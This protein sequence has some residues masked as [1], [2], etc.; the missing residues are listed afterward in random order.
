MIAG[1][2]S[3]LGL[4]DFSYVEGGVCQAN[5][6]VS[7]YEGPANTQA[8][9]IC[10]AGT[11]TCDIYGSTL[12]ACSGQ[13]LPQAEDDCNTPE[14][15]N[16]DGIVEACPEVVAEEKSFTSFGSTGN[17]VI[18]DSA[19]DSEGN[20]YIVGD[21]TGTI[22]LGGDDLTSVVAE[23]ATGG[24]GGAGGSEET[25]GSG[26]VGSGESDIFVAKFDSTGT[27][28]WS[29][30][31]GDA[32]YQH[33]SAIAIDHDDH[34][35]LTGD[36]LGSIPFDGSAFDSTDDSTQNAFVAKLDSDGKYVWDQT[37]DST[38]D[39]TLY[40][41]DVA[42]NSE[43]SVYIIGFYG[44][45]I[46]DLNIPTPNN[47]S[48]KDDDVY[49]I[50]LDQQGTLTWADDY[51]FLEINFIDFGVGVSIDDNDSIILTGNFATTS[52]FLAK[53][54]S[55]HSWS[56]GW[57][58][59]LDGKE[60]VGR[61]LQVL[62]DSGN[63]IYLLGSYE[64]QFQCYLYSTLK[65]LDVTSSGSSDFFIAKIS[66]S[67]DKAVWSKTFGAS[68]VAQ[69][70]L[71]DVFHDN[72]SMKLALDETGDLV[73]TGSYSG[74]VSFDGGTSYLTA[75]NTD[76]SIFVAKLDPANGTTKWSKSFGDVEKVQESFSLATDS[77]DNV[78]VFG[79]FE[80]SILFNGQTIQSKGLNDTLWLKLGP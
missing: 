75:G 17:E 40:S 63:N 50:E 16:C 35:I 34:L 25:G 62:T 21:F 11:Q 48:D 9:G 58:C 6:E 70:P 49:L 8:V 74:K 23:E 47:D 13:I 5:E 56:W 46:A 59:Y 39:E 45:S 29:K 27:H 57:T 22:N 73:V 24:S 15:E 72:P 79:G 44:D 1:C 55:S 67:G 69:N 19:K 68:G 54:T 38:T 32:S 4:D 12:T 7:C 3:I 77:A 80:G 28:V 26:G 42:I 31:F 78:H 18:Y 30:S 36:Y 41:R 14:D 51:Y 71:D 2:N 20:F 65:I 53:Y 10:K 61:G 64:G 43:N 52:V 37:F 60:D 66:P 76:K 33:V